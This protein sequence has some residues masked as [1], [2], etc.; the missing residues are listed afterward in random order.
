[1][2][3][4]KKRLL[5]AVFSPLVLCA[6]ILADMTAGAADIGMSGIIKSFTGGNVPDRTRTIILEI[7][8]VRTASALL[9][10]MA[11]SVCGLMMQTLF[12][13]PL[14]GPYVLGI[15]SGASLGAALF[16]L[17]IPAAWSGS[18]IIAGAGL[19]GAAWIGAGAVMAVMAIASARLKDI[20]TVLILGLMLSAGIDAMVQALQFFSDETA[21]KSYVLWT[22]GTLGGVS[23]G[24]LP[25]M[26]AAVL[27][28][29]VL[30]GFSVKSLN[31]LLLGEEYAATMGLDVRTARNVI[32]ASTVLLAGT[33]TAFCGPIGFLGLAS[34]HIARFL[35]GTSDHR[36]LLPG[37]AMTG[38]ILMTAC[39]I[40]SKVSHLP[41]NVMT[42]LLGIPVVIWIVLK[43]KQ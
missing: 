38:A 19:A 11:V 41:V 21:L 25:V 43:F 12:R 22:M 40:L 17:G 24:Q 36:I 10:G 32:Y 30:A 9:A 33:V 28:G 14:A 35:T 39:D 31:L 37:T 23:S 26:A 18:S 6:L 1:M 3:T 8:G 7:R 16:V 13:N 15:N 4:G 5:F 27:S 2:M 42:S 20:M 34:P 29:A